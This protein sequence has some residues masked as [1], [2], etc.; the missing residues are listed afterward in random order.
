MFKCLDNKINVKIFLTFQI[1]F[2]F[3]F[4]EYFRPFEEHQRRTNTKQVMPLLAELNFKCCSYWH[5]RNL[6]QHTTTL[7]LHT[8]NKLDMI[9]S[10]DSFYLASSTYAEITFF[11]LAR[12]LTDLL[13]QAS[14][15][16]NVFQRHKART[17]LQQDV[18]KKTILKTH[19]EN[20]KRDLTRALQLLSHHCRIACCTNRS[21]G[22]IV[23]IHKLWFGQRMHEAWNGSIVNKPPF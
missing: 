12:C 16:L 22:C 7:T 13:K 19:F 18:R 3:H 9:W 11:S 17:Y 10:L 8:C 2:L 4:F 14:R 1:Q 23:C 6:F 5:S 20:T 21:M 15:I